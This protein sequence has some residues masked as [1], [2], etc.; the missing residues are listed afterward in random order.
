LGIRERIDKTECGELHNLYSVRKYYW[1]Y[2]MK[3]DEMD[4]AHNIYGRDGKCSQNF[5]LKT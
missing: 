1:D 5:G 2:Q 4:G 3:E